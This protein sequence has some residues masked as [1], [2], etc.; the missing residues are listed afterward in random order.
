MLNRK[1]HIE[2]RYMNSAS[3]G[4]EIVQVSK[5]FEVFPIGYVRS[6]LKRCHNAPPQGSE[7]A[8]DAKLEIDPAFIQ[9][10]DGIVSGQDIWILTAPQVGALCP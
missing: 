9:C 2:E 1:R 5:S 4:G 3:I 10:I 8:P 6:A 7:G